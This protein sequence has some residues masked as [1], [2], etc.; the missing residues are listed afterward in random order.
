MSL[1]DVATDERHTG[2]VG[3]PVPPP[4]DTATALQLSV[5]AR[6][7]AGFVKR[8]ARRLRRFSGQIGGLDG[9]E[10]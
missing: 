1:L 3:T 9:S 7:N 6:R 8:L 2:G 5:D 4:P 10:E